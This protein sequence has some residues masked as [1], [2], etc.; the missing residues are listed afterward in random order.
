MDAR[1]P[2]SRAFTIVLVTSVVSQLALFM[3]GM[4][5]AWVL[6]DLTDAPAAFALLNVATTL[7][8]F[9]LALVAGALAD[10]ADRRGIMLMGQ[11]ASVVTVGVY[12]VLAWHDAH[13]VATIL[14]LT[15]VLGVIAAMTGPAWMATLPGLVPRERL[16]SAMSVSSGA[17]NLVMAIGPALAGILVAMQG[18]LAVFALNAVLLVAGF[19]ALG[20]YRPEPRQGLP[21]E[22]L[23][24]AVRMGIRYVR[25]D[26]A[27]KRI[28]L[29]MA[30]YA[31]A[32]VALIALLPAVAR[33]QLQAGPALF[34]LLSGAGGVGAVVAL[35]I[36]PAI[37][38]RYSPDV[39]VFGAMVVQAA[40]L[41]TMAQTT[42]IP[43]ALAALVA[44]GIALLLWISSVMTVLQ[45]VLPAW[46]RGRG[47]AVY[48]LALQ[49][50]FTVGAIFWGG[51]AE[52]VGVPATLV[53][54]AAVMAIAAPMVFAIRLAAYVDV[55]ARPMPFVDLPTATSVHDEDGP[56]LVTAEW[57]VLPEQRAAFLAAMRR[58][59]R[60]L[61][62]NGAIRFHLVED[63]NEPGRILESF[64]MAT[65]AEFQRI[66]ER[67]TAADKAVEDALRAASGGELAP[68]RAHRTLD[69]PMS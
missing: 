12:A 11:V 16:A 32:S 52:R 50:T 51:L 19:F 66:P 20:S 41:A 10:V 1:H 26:P 53:A 9:L 17:S 42:R 30:P 21:P 46:I 28:I 58:V 25:Y 31:F 60:G 8:T 67:T 18:P 27:L 13:T 38:E 37:R 62:R 54:A 43:V 65:W 4:A 49:G 39:I 61:K 22:H 3:N 15:A 29:K 59:H 2:R 14:G 44:G 57:R 63:V 55:D 7:P 69:V 33:F 40:V 36:G 24:S 35:A 34:G 68:L 5:S 47:V 64:T 6:T 48:L 45:A 56:I 23:G